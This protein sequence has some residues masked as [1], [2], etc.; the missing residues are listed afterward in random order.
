M[1]CTSSSP[2]SLGRVGTNR[3]ADL[4]NGSIS[5]IIIQDQIS[6]KSLHFLATPPTDE[7]LQISE[8]ERNHSR[9]GHFQKR[10]EYG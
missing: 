7:Y 1:E 4:R 3:F 9:V 8:L 5:S 6:S 10:R 2:S